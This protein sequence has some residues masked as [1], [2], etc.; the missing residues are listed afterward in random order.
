MSTKIRAWRE[1]LVAQRVL[2]TGDGLV[3]V[4]RGDY[5]MVVTAKSWDD[6]ARVLALLDPQLTAT[7]GDE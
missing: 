6:L 2:N 4:N 1:T 7:D 3:V 5:A